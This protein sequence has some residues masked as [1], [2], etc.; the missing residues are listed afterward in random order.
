MENT[1]A[2]G[3]SHGGQGQRLSELLTLE[4]SKL[5]KNVIIYCPKI[6]FKFSLYMYAS[7]GR[8]SSK[9]HYET[10]NSIR[11]KIH[12][13]RQKSMI[14]ENFTEFKELFQNKQGGSGSIFNVVLLDRV[15]IFYIIFQHSTSSSGGNQVDGL[16]RDLH[17][18]RML[19]RPLRF[20]ISQDF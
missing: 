10:L 9:I 14:F 17:L 13:E 12:R 5:K 8:V 15:M 2:V 4:I 18:V 20:V 7:S 11:R 19:L 3:V 1:E 6:S 16:P